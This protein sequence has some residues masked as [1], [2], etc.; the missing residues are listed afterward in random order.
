MRINIKEAD[1]KEAMD[2]A[3]KIYK[4]KIKIPD[5]FKDGKELEADYKGFLGE[6]ILSKFLGTKL[7]ELTTG[8]LDKYDFK[9]KNGKTYDLKTRTK[10]TLL[11][12]KDRVNKVDYYI[13]AQLKGNYPTY[14][15]VDFIGYIGAEMAKEVGKE[16]T[17]FEKQVLIVEPKDLYPIDMFLN[18]FYRNF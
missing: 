1:R 10:P 12:H 8:K 7:P 17:L 11:I 6:I 9:D 3:K 4:D 18:K 13:L 5:K 16:K 15:A 2:L 14:Q